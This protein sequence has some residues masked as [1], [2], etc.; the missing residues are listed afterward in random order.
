MHYKINPLEIKPIDPIYLENSLQNSRKSAIKL[1]KPASSVYLSPSV[2]RIVPVIEI[3]PW[4]EEQKAKF[5]AP[6]Q[7]DEIHECRSLHIIDNRN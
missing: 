3:K 2:E 5:A 4:L 7:K 1:K 6:I